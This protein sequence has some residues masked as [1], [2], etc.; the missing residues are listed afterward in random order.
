MSQVQ[1]PLEARFLDACRT[2]GLRVTPQYGIGPIHVDFA[3]VDKKV[4]IECDSKE[5]HGS[6]EA[7]E[8]DRQ[9]DIIYSVNGWTVLRLLGPDIAR[10]GDEIASAIRNDIRHEDYYF[11]RCRAAINGD[12]NRE[13][14]WV[15]DVAKER[16]LH[17]Y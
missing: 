3:V 5:W 11:P 9:R 14:G 8:T 6:D 2:Q 15:D 4:A 7:H 10:C 12:Y 1:S 13:D 16:Y 17:D